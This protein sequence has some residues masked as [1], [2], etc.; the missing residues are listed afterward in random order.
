MA[1]PLPDR[2][3][4]TTGD[5]FFIQV[6]PGVAGL[7]SHFAARQGFKVGTQASLRRQR[8]Q[9]LTAPGAPYMAQGE[10]LKR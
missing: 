4:S 7:V 9:I 6:S 2:F 10:K 8:A 1:A 3:E 5:R